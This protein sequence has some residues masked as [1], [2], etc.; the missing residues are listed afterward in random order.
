M[1]IQ[2]PAKSR[3]SSEPHR[4]P[5]RC[6]ADAGFPQVRALSVGRVVARMRDAFLGERD[7]ADILYADVSVSQREAFADKQQNNGRRHVGRKP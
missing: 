5:Q 7:D 4:Q 2:R 3:S 1:K 6:E